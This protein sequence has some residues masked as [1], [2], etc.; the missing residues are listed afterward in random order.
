[1][2]ELI[3]EGRKRYRAGVPAGLV[4]QVGY[5][6]PV[7]RFLWTTQAASKVVAKAPV[8]VSCSLG[9]A[10]A[11]LI[12]ENAHVLDQVKLLA[13]KRMKCVR[14]PHSTMLLR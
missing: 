10:T 11:A 14:N 13:T 7:V 4:R 5:V 1:L 9:S 12:A 8:R 2:A 6:L 3:G